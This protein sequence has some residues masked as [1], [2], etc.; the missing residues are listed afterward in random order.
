MI[1]NEDRF[2]YNKLV[3][4][5]LHGVIREV[6]RIVAQKGLPGTH[7]FVIKFLTRYPG[8]IL[9]DSLRKQYY[10]NEMTII[11]QYQFFDLQVDQDSFS[12][13]LSFNDLFES[14]TIPYE[15]MMLF[16]DPSVHF[17]IPF[18]LDAS[19]MPI[20]QKDDPKSVIFNH[21]TDKEVTYGNVI[22][23]DAFRKSKRDE[24]QKD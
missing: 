24:E 23:L 12:V 20:N 16:S 17:A 7:Y 2:S 21:D 4:E 13:T 8:V 22:A 19:S 5:A 3:R 6:L 10:P 18:H 9:S 1:L 14:L 15:A 11:L